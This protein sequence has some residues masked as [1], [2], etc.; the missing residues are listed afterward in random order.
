MRR[1]EVS[2]VLPA[3]VATVS[4]AF[5]DIEA[6]QSVWDP[7]S[8]VRVTY[9]DGRNQEFLM[10]VDRDGTEERVRTIRFR[11]PDSINFFTPVPPPAMSWHRGAWL[12]APVSGGC[13]VTAVR[14]YALIS[15]AEPVAVRSA[16]AGRTEGNAF[17][18]AF[19]ARLTRILDRFAETFTTRDTERPAVLTS[20]GEGAR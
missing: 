2:G 19:G 14:E 8:Q 5:W 20:A 3:T 17:H 13:R 12:F 7:I 10:S 15:D 9:C 1:L 11:A 4:D 6:W 18:D 16:T